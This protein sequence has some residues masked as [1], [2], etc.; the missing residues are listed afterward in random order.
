MV[1]DVKTGECY[2]ADHL[3]EAAL[4]GFLED[5]KAPPSVEA[6]RVRALGREG[7]EPGVCR[8]R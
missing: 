1:R 4:E 7:R 2:R 3:L 8:G 5:T 6:A